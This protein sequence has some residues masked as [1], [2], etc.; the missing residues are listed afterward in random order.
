MGRLAFQSSWYVS[1]LA[2]LA[3]GLTGC[4][5][6]ALAER[7]SH[8]PLNSDG[9]ANADGG[10]GD[11]GNS[12]DGDDGD[13]GGD[14]ERDGG[15]EEPQQLRPK[16]VQ[17]DSQV[18][19]IGDSYISWPSHTFPQDIEKASGQK[20]RIEAVGGMSMATGGIGGP[21]GEYI[22]NQFDRAIEADADAHTVLMDGGGNDVLVGWL[23]DLA[24]ESC[25][26][27]G[28]SML[29]R[30]QQVVTDAIAAA[31]KLIDR[32]AAAGIRDVV[33][34]FYPHVPE[35]RPIGG[36][37]PNEILDF[38]L[39]QIEAFCDSREQ[40]TDGA[41]RCHFIDM[42]PVFEGHDPDWFN[43]DI[44]PNSDGS[45]AMAE[46]VWAKMRTW[47]VGQKEDSGCC[48]P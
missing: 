23:S 24:I 9:G 5:A 28:S 41:L 39:P 7:A 20:W 26:E 21:L 47:C 1:L 35:G 15:T 25:K 32:M 3:A 27:T 8:R 37:H 4:G 18:I 46:E 40:A 45:K 6:E 14:A 22:P 34:F 17:K 16:C 19:V 29:P 31:G 38:A 10:I 43:T 33:Y 30:C 13:L 12:T 48:E 11:G 36:A 2:L 42:V 44:H